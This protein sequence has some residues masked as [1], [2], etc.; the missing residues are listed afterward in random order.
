MP[1][2]R[3]T[4]QTPAG[5]AVAR[6]AGGVLAAGLLVGLGLAG[7]ITIP[8]LGTADAE[9]SFLGLPLEGPSRIVAGLGCLLIGGFLHAWLFWASPAGRYRR[10]HGLR[11]FLT[12]ALAGFLLGNLHLLTSLFGAYRLD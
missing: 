5:N 4:S 2:D 12:L 10:F 8:A 11:L 1:T 3:F 9:P 7:L 6:W